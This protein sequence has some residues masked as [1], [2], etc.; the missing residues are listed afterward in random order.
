MTRRASVWP[1]IGLMICLV[2]LVALAGIA[3]VAFAAGHNAIPGWEKSVDA[4]ARMVSNY[5]WQLVAIVGS[6]LIVF[7]IT[8]WYKALHKKRYRRKPYAW[9]M[10]IASFVSVMAISYS[11][12]TQRYDDIVASVVI[13]FVVA[14][15]NI[16]IV[17]AIFK[18]APMPVVDVLAEGA[19]SENTMIASILAGRRGESEDPT[20]PQDR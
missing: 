19:S 16:A 18:Y 8:Q 11:C 3:S 9:V 13:G 1:L 7:R 4:A 12:W 10:D 6:P 15:F 20:T 5:G 2:L 14:S 17:K